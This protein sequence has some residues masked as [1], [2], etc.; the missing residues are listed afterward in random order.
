MIE[1]E[2]ISSSVASA[3]VEQGS[4]TQEIARNVQQAASRTGEVSRNISGVTTGIA[5][6]GAAAQEVLGSSVK[7]ARQSETLRSEVDRF[8]ASIRAA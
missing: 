6:T 1:I 4:A 5:A 2:E 7:L 8:L 3:I